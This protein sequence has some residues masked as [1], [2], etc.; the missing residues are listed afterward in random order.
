MIGLGLVVDLA[1]RPAL[2][3]AATVTLWAYGIAFVTSRWAVESLAYARMEGRRVSWAADASHAREHLL[4]L[5]RWLPSSPEPQAPASL[6]RWAVLHDRTPLQAPWH[7]AL[8]ITGGAAAVTGLLLNTAGSAASIGAVAVLGAAA[9]L[10]VAAL[11]GWRIPAVALGAAM[12]LWVYAAVF[13]AHPVVATLP[14]LAVMAAYLHFSAQC[15]DTMGHLGRVVR[16]GLAGALTPL[17]RLVVGHRT[18]QVLQTKDPA[19]G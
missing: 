10:A 16:G 8:A 15:P 5:T 6:T 19:R 17:G 9:A 18:W 7:V 1:A 13:A 4:A 14:W 12:L 2:A 3:M 11:P